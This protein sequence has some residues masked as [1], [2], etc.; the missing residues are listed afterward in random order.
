M[1][2]ITIQDVLDCN[3]ELTEKA[4]SFKIHLHDACGKQSCGV[5]ALGDQAV[6][7]NAE[8]KSTLEAFFG[9]RGYKLLFDDTSTVFWL[10]Q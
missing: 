1:N 9:K 8:L 4:L 3:R 10:I 7:G 6:S 2:Y 5:E